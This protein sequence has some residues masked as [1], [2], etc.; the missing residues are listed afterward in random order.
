MADLYI[1]GVFEDSAQRDFLTGLLE[2]VTRVAGHELHMEPRLTNGCRFDFLEQHL[3]D[4]GGH[5]VGVVIGVDGKKE[6]PAQK[7]QAM[8]QRAQGSLARVNVLWSV[9]CPSIEAW[10]MADVDAVPMVL[11]DVYGPTV[12]PS[13]PPPIPKAESRAKEALSRWVAELLGEPL[14]RGGREHAREIGAALRPEH[15]SS[16]RH[17]DLNQLLKQKI[18]EFLVRCARGGD[19]RR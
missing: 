1:G 14:L 17:P 11:K 16:V 15:V 6:S 2:R 7:S 5:T 9:A 4:L 3:G 12:R 19:P 8:S 10:M 18:P 13:T